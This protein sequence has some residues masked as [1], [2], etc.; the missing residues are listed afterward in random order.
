MH[1][2]DCPP[3]CYVTVIV[4]VL[5]DQAGVV[6]C[7]KA[8]SRQT[9]PADLM[10]V[11]IVDN[12]SEPPIDTLEQYSFPV[13]VVE[14]G[15]PGSYAARNV[16]A[17]LAYGNVL[18]FTDADCI[19]QTDWIEAGL[20]ILRKGGNGC[21]VGGEVII[22]A[23]SVRSGVGLYQHL[24]GFQQRQ[25]IE[26][27]GFSVTANL[28]CTRE[29][30]SR[31]GPFDERLLSGGDREWSWRAGRAGLQLIFAE[32]AIVQTAPRASLKA[33]IRQTRRVTAGRYL[34]RSHSLD[35]TGPVGLQPHRGAM[36]SLTWIL[37]QPEIS[38]WERIKVFG[39]AL[40]LK[41]TAAFETMRLRLGG[42]A[43]RR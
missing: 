7:L 27:K 2:L 12:G 5:N 30:F 14:C 11:L 10:E 28:I 43:E 25:N 34:L 38:P 22:T 16:G 15:T 31:V 36:A 32:D 18:A 8:L 41:A 13:R 29:Q 20:R 23:P 33:A 24:A 19:P 17:K 1:D 6:A 26:R 37:R 40:V 9:Y 4:P 39:V 3:Q 21:L 42:N 35:W